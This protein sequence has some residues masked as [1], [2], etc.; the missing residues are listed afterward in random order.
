MIYSHEL[1]GASDFFYICYDLDLAQK[2]TKLNLT[3]LGYLPYLFIA[4]I[5]TIKYTIPK[6]IENQ[7]KFSKACW[8]KPEEHFFKDI[9]PRDMLRFTMGSRDADPKLFYSS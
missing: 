8:V 5:I 2:M 9:S 4:K 3:N 1:V 6:L 7:S